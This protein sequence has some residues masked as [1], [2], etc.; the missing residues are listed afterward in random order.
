MHGPVYAPPKIN[1]AARVTDRVARITSHLCEIYFVYLVRINWP[2]AV[3]GHF[4]SE[5]LGRRRTDKRRKVIAG[6][7]AHWHLHKTLLGQRPEVSN[8]LAQRIIPKNRIRLAKGANNF[9]NTGT[10]A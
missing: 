10:F 1:S 2:G 6:T 7:Q 8:G 4:R 9:Y 5:S 3:A